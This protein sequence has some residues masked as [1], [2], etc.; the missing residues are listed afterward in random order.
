MVHENQSGAQVAVF[1]RDLIFETKIK[2][3]GHS[4]GVGTVVVRSVTELETLLQ[5][6]AVRLLIV[7]LNTAGPTALDAIRAA[8][9]TA[10]VRVLAFVSHVDTDLVD[11]AIQA[12]ADMVMPRSRFSS[13]LPELLAQSD[14]EP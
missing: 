12:G 5:E 1:I 11:P 13:Q 6:S 10:E 14:E 7:D 2:S 4:L 3:T 9:S 8:K